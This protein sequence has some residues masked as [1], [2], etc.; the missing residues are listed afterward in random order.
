M[1]LWDLYVI[2]IVL[3]ISFFPSKSKALEATSSAR[4]YKD[5]LKQHKALG[6]LG[7]FFIQPWFEYH[8]QEQPTT[9]IS[10][11]K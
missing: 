1:F 3:A 7:L 6:N 2:T 5:K 10:T 11:E 9:Q 8:R 4:M